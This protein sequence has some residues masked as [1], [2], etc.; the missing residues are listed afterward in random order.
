MF[1][2]FGSYLLRS[3][4]QEDDVARTEEGQQIKYEPRHRRYCGTDPCFEVSVTE[5]GR[6]EQSEHSYSRNTG[7]GL[8]ATNLPASREWK[9]DA[10]DTK[11][12]Q[13]CAKKTKSRIKKQH[14]VS[15]NVLDFLCLQSKVFVG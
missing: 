9:I 5:I 2:G 8:S 14:K 13:R 7:E 12:H 15:G 4:P 3:F 6:A 11:D 1:G 10:D